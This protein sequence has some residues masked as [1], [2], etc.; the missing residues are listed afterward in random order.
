M[1]V[2]LNPNRMESIFSD[3][4]QLHQHQHQQDQQ[5]ELEDEEQFHMVSSSHINHSDNNNDNNHNHN[6]SPSQSP[7]GN[8]NL[9][10]T[11]RKFSNFVLTGKFKLM[12]SLYNFVHPRT[13]FSKP[14]PYSFLFLI[15]YFENELL[16]TPLSCSAYN[17]Y[18]L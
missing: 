18:V 13:Y 17:Y 15:S 11:K 5:D 9:Q 16:V 7:N 6:P 12:A 1:K 8:N 2:I 3:P 4:Q 14:N 10:Q